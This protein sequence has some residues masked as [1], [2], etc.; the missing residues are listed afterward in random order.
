MRRREFL[1]G[2][3]ASSVLLPSAAEALMGGRRAL[4]GGASTYTFV[5]SEAAAIVAAFTTPA[6]NSRKALIDTTVGALK[7]ANIWSALDALWVLAAAD[8]QAALINWKNPGTFTGI[9]VNS[10]AFTTDR[11]FQ[12]NGTSSRVRTQF[13]PNS[14]GVNYTQDSA[15]GWIWSLTDRQDNQEFGNGSPAPRLDVGARTG[16]NQMVCIVNDGTTSTG[17]VSASTSIGM[18]GASRISSATK[19][20]WRNGA[21]EGSDFAVAST[22]L[23][24]AELWICGGNSTNFSQKQIAMAA[25]GNSLSGKEVAFYNAILAYMQAVGAA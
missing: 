24:T 1:A 22:G 19:R 14:S 11:G 25:L 21:Q 10:P 20:A 13:T 15:S 23:P 4:L 12:G 7:T 8:S 5:N 3:A 2:A 9:T 6:T 17:P 16:A 18:F